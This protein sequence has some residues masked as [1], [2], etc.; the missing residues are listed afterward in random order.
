MALIIR[1]STNIARTIT[2]LV[3]RDGTNTPRTISELWVRDTTNTPRKVYST[4]TPLSAVASDPSVFGYDSGSG[5]ATTYSTTI[6]PSGGTAPF[7]YAWTCTFYSGVTIPTATAPASASS[8]F[9]QTSIGPEDYVYSYWT[10]TVTD[11]ALATTTVEI[12]A[13]FYSSL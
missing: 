3:I 8:A 10:C 12:S 2:G 7:T 5:T 1:D 13:N 11:A 9:T 6:T 4:G